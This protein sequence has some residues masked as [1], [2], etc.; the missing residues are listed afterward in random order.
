MPRGRKVAH[1]SK[2]GV[3]MMKNPHKYVGPIT[4]GG[5]LYRSSWEER[6]FFYM[7]HNLNVIEWSSEGVAIPYIFRLDGKVHKYY[8]DII[9]KIKTRDGIKT[10]VIE[11]KPA[12]QTVEPSKPKNRSLSRKERYEK[13]M[14]TYIKN[15]DKWEGAKEYCEKNG[16]EFEIFTEKE[17]FGKE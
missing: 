15:V 8:P 16:Y 3:Y 7:D 2:K 12:W 6:M 14:Y 1:E 13:E 9:A 10:F 17:I 4:E 11:V 5:V